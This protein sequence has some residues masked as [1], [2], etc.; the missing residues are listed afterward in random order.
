MKSFHR[1]L[2]NT[3][4]ANVTTGF[5]WFALTF[6]IYLETRSVLA[7]GV[8]GGAYMGLV[9]LCSLFFGVVVDHTRKKSVMALS[10]LITVSA[11]LV[12]GALWL[13][14]PH[15]WFLRVDSPAFWLFVLLILGGSVV[16]NMRNIALST[17]VTLLVPDGSRDRANGL[18]GM[19]QGVAFMVTSVFS[20]LAIG[21]LGMGPTLLIAIV[22][23]CGALL[24]LIT[25]RIPEDR[26]ATAAEA[27]AAVAADAAAHAEA[28]GEADGSS[29]AAA[30]APSVPVTAAAPEPAR[31]PT[32]RERIDLS[33][34]LRSIRSVP[35]LLALILFACFNNLVGGVY[36][37]LMDPYGLELL[38]AQ[39]WGIILGV[40]STG[41]IVGGMI[42]AK[43]GLGANPVR[44][45]LLLNIGVAAVG[46][47]F[48]IRESWILF[49]VGIFVYMSMIPAAEA[50]EQTVLQRVVPFERQGRVFGFAQSVEVAAAPISAFLVA[51]MAEFW[52]I[53]WAES[54]PGRAGVSWLLG[55]GSTRGIALMFLLAGVVMLVAVAVAFASPQYRRLSTYYAASRADPAATGTGSAA[56]A[57]L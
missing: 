11:Y 2:V 37:A 20:G 17:T 5:L 42:V 56:G 7:T 4:I 15:E 57:P 41:F 23:T 31:P 1:V 26:I 55:E 14:L 46:G 28:G 27:A 54:E 25:V 40:T 48:A 38:S 36:M 6:W 52:V 3:A 16:E 39:A 33:G 10:S 13:V 35:G 30:P 45:L 53:P 8:I 50:A 47:T 19:V 32:L 18:V 22:A 51:P 9:A 49:A 29:T 34:S 21:F 43:A 12:A 24:H 44:T